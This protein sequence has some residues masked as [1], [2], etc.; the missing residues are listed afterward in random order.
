MSTN[1]LTKFRK[2][3]YFPCLSGL[4]STF[5]DIVCPS[6]LEVLEGASQLLQAAVGRS[7]GGKQ[8]LRL[9]QEPLQLPQAAAVQVPVLHQ[10]LHQGAPLVRPLHRALPVLPELGQLQDEVTPGCV[11]TVKV[12]VCPLYFTKSSLFTVRSYLSS[13]SPF[14]SR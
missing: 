14:C 13:T 2:C 11:D 8:G 1:S 3:P 6:H 10:P 7:G 9:R 12:K 5:P 4:Y